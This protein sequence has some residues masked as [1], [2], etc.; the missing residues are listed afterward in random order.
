MV[1]NFD[2]TNGIWIGKDLHS[3]HKFDEKLCNG[4]YLFFEREGGKISDLGCGYGLYTEELNK[5]TECIGYDGNPY[6]ELISP[7]LCNVL[8]LSKKQKIRKTEWVLSLEVGNHIPPKYESIFIK[9]LTDTATKGIVLSWAVEN[10]GGLG[11]LNKKNNNY[12]I[13]QL[14]LYDFKYDNYSTQLLRS[15]TTYKWFRQS[16]L[17]FRKQ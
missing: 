11:H 7:G 9:N 10:Q 2:K 3:Y 17:V 15:N 8:D 16:L 5:L 1:L 13:E 6:T 12:I 4:L 14:N